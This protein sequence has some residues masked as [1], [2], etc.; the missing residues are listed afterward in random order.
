MKRAAS[1]L[2]SLALGLA[3]CLARAEEAP[4]A[5]PVRLNVSM[6]FGSTFGRDTLHGFTWGFKPTLVAYPTHGGH[7]PGLGVFG[8]Y[9][10][11]AETRAMWSLGGIG[12]ARLASF[13][14]FDFRLGGLVA[15]RG[16]AEGNDDARRL[17][18]GAI[19]ELTVPAYLYD[20]RVGLRFDGT[21]DDEGVSATSLLLEV[22]VVA[23]LGL[24]MYG[25][26]G[27]R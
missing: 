16:S 19:A 2:S 13:D 18:L 10:I 22:D 12:S 14:I 9:L 20:F 23:V 26:S 3:T 25:A 7:G 21:F 4:P 11:D 17:L 27:A 6:P 15:E 1:V 8:E 24:V 5:W